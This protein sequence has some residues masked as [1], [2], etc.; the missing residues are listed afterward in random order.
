MIWMKNMK[1]IINVSIK[2]LKCQNYRYRFSVPV[3]LIV[4]WSESHN[5]TSN[6]LKITSEHCLHISDNQLNGLSG[7][8]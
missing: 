1:M 3:Y 6:L 2:I 7:Y 4:S 5:V 8:C